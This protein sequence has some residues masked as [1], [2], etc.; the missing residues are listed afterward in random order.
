MTKNQDSIHIWGDDSTTVWIR[1]KGS[2]DGSKPAGLAQ[3]IEGSGFKDGG[4]LGEDGID[5][6]LAVEVEKFKAYQGGVTVKNRVTST[7]RSFKFQFLQEDPLS[8]EV[9]WDHDGITDGDEDNPG[10]LA[11]YDIP[12]S[13]GYSEW[14]FLVDFVDAGRTKRLVCSASAGERGTV[15]HK[16]TEMTVLEV[17]FDLTGGAYVL[18]DDEAFVDAIPAPAGGGA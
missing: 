7:E 9:F 3:P 16:N 4:W 15:P 2:G 18:T 13:V 8:T 10:T 14:E 6:D 12:E 11:R 5:L 1:R 17:T